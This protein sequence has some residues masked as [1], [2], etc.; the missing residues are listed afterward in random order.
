MKRYLLHRSALSLAAVCALLLASC[1]SYEPPPQRA[2]VYAE[3]SYGGGTVY[4]QSVDDFYDPL[5][6]YGEWVVVGSYGRCWRPSRID[7]DWRPYS[8]GVWVHSDAG[9]CWQSDE[10][11][12][13]AT[14]HYGRWDFDVSFGWIWFPEIQWAP[15]WVEWRS[16]GGY[17]GWAPMPPRHRERRDSRDSTYVFVEENRFVEP[18]RPNKVIVNNTTIIQKTVNVTN[19]TVVNNTVINEGPR[20]DVIERASGRKVSNVPVAT[21]RNKQEAPVVAKHPALSH[22]QAKRVAPT[23]NTEVSRPAPNVETPRTQ[24][25]ERRVRNPEPSAPVTT[26]PAAPQREERP[27][28]TRKEQRRPAPANVEQPT[29]RVAPVTTAPDAPRREERPSEVRKEKPKHVPANVEQPTN[30]VAPPPST[31]A[32]R[33]PQN[34]ETPRRQPQ[35]ERPRK[36]EPAEPATRAPESP[37]TRAPESIRREE[38]QPEVRKEAVP[39]PA[40]T[41]KGQPQDKKKK[42]EQKP[43]KDDDDDKGGKP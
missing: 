43:K 18:V 24:P 37:T 7:R 19:T 34:V 31:P 10:P 22:G 8:S 2:V 20:V 35:E 36:A 6:P 28:E 25:Q 16:G 11:W 38:R 5:T 21:F 32:E 14:Y 17:V 27:S 29:N 12:G 30:R 3:A 9:W 15:A 40:K 4:I 41:D 39:P 23:S 42:H 1:T 13:W 33:P 26:A